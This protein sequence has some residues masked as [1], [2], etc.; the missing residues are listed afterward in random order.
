VVEE[1]VADQAKLQ[2]L[3]EEEVLGRVTVAQHAG[4]G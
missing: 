1:R 2:Q 4:S 3:P